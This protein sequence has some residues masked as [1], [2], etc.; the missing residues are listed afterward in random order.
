M[1]ARQRCSTCQGEHDICRADLACKSVLYFC[2]CAHVSAC[3]AMLCLVLQVGG[4]FAI[5]THQIVNPRPNPIRH[6]R[7]G[8]TPFGGWGCVL[9]EA[10]VSPVMRSSPSI[11]LGRAVSLA[12]EPPRATRFQPE[13]IGTSSLGNP[14]IFQFFSFCSFSALLWLNQVCARIEYLCCHPIT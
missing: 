2:V 14:Q 13:S 11:N 1:C 8:G 12:P 9:N 5:S 6:T 4:Q 10:Y 7:H 3:V